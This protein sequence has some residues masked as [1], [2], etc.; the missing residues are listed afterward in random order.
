MSNLI[1][2]AVLKVDWAYRQPDLPSVP[3][4]PS[5]VEGSRPA[6][7]LKMNFIFKMPSA[8]LTLHAAEAH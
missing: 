6:L 4:V 8:I 1:L 5:L 7:Y 3:P 2:A